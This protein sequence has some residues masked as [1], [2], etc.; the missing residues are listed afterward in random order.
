[1]TTGIR[2]AR[3]V[4]VLEDGGQPVL[5]EVE[6]W[7][8]QR[9]EVLV[10]IVASGVCASDA[11]VV[12]GRSPV[13]KAPCVLGHEGAGVVEEVGPGVRSVSPGDRVIITLVG[14][15][16]ECSY[17]VDAK[18]WLCNGPD[19]LRAMTGV[20]SDGRTRV[21]LDG[22]DLFPFMGAGTMAE[23]S[24]VRAAQ[25]V[26]VDPDLPLDQVCLLGCGVVTGTGAALKTARVQPGDAVVVIGCGGVGL[27]VIQGAR[28]AGATSIIAADTK[29]D[30]LELARTL[31]ATHTV[32]VGS[33]D[34]FQQ[35]LSIHPEGVDFAFEVVGIPQ[36]AADS[37]KLLRRGG[38]TVLVGSCPPGSVIPVTRENLMMER[39]IMTTV[40]GSTSPQLDIPK[41]I[42]AYRAGRLQLGELVSSRLL[43]TD[44]AQAFAALETGS[45]ARTVLT[46]SE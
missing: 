25:L 28:L 16:G 4:V 22:K 33:V 34:L 31:G 37:L 26:K 3:A 6:V 24:V 10:R 14:P 11:H 17:C 5:E 15:C 20:M 32:D 13:A 1:M 27:N 19:T 38:T 36:L 8:P 18:P 2:I 39:R 45:A 9:G 35:V 29:P 42:R 12:N 23:F 43:L 44:Y 46:F 7:P 21:R 30:K 41:L 40:A